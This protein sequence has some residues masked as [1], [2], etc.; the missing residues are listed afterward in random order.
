MTNISFL[1]VVNATPNSFSDGHLNLNYDY[2][3]NQLQKFK[4]A[5]Y[6]LDIGAE[7]SAPFN[8][9]VTFK[10]EWERLDRYFNEHLESLKSFKIISIDTYKP[11]TM[12]MF[13][14]KYE[15]QFDHIVWNDVS[16]VIDDECLN[17][18]TSFPS[19]DYVLCH[20]LVPDREKTLDHMEYL[21]SNLSV[22]SIK[23]FFEEGLE[24]FKHAEVDQKRII[25][26]PC[27]GFSK[28]TEQNLA[29]LHNLFEI[30]PLSKRWLI[31]ISKKS[32]LRKLVL[33]E[34]P[35][36]VGDKQALLA[37]SEVPHWSFLSQFARDFNKVEE[38]IFRVHE[39]GNIT[40]L[41]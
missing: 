28:T 3:S 37:A 4:T 33:E 8:D 31:G 2:Q 12:K 7:S 9:P 13:L 11:Q 18:L 41:T 20:T 29:L 21:D 1:G 24:K 30:A 16:G 32:F 40:K 36:L 39:V 6:S 5:D 17:L 25:L 35:E 19:L 23:R 34:S 14:E 27:F 10:E 26:D 15:H 22:E 38:L